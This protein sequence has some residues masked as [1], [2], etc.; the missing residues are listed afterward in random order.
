MVQLTDDLLRLL[1]TEAARRGISR[2]ALIRQ[3]LSEHLA[4]SAEAIITRSIVD[5]YTRVPQATPVE[6]GPLDAQ[7]DRSTAE[8][9]RRLSEEERA[10]GHEPW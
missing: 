10:A 6:W 7:A 9:G 3:I 5:G 8:A 2:S 1:D 4:A